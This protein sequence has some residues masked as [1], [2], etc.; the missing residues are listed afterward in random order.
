MKK[1]FVLLSLFLGLVF[2]VI[3]AYSLYFYFH[4]RETADEIHEPLGREQSTK[5]EVQV[6][7]DQQEPLSFLIAGVDTR[8]DEHSGRSDT[9]IVMTVNPR[10]ESVKMLS[11]PRDTR[12]TIVGRNTE[13]KINHA[14]AFGGIQMTIDTVEEFLNIPIDHYMSINMEGFKLII[15]ALGGISITNDLLE[16]HQDGFHFPKGELELSGE[17]ALAYSRMRKEDP[18]GDFGR[19][20]RQRQVVEAVIQE[21]AHIRSI[22]RAGSILDAVG[23]SIKTDLSLESMWKIQSNYKEARHHVEQM[24]LTGNGRIIEGIYYLLLPDEEIARVRRELRVHL[25]LE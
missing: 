10:E 11:I 18:R 24:E 15:D 13:D 9:I 21:G 8:G 7:V 1:P 25:E 6:D 23:A 5:R 12:T 3:V 20:E 16:F 2:V 17:E 4:V 14:Y 19:N 22:T